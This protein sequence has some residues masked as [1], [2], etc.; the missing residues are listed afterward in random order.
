MN[1]KS[2]LNSEFLNTAYFYKAPETKASISYIEQIDLGETNGPNGFPMK[3]FGLKI[4]Q[5]DIYCD[6]IIFTKDE[7]NTFILINT[8]ISKL[9]N[10]YIQLATINDKSIRKTTLKPKSKLLLR[11]INSNSDILIGNNDIDAKRLITRIMHV[12]NSIAVNNR[13]GPATFMVISPKLVHLIQNIPG[14]IYDTNGKI[15]EYEVITQIGNVMGLSVFVNYDSHDDIILVGRY[16]S[17]NNLA[18]VALIENDIQIDT[19]HITWIGAIEEYSPTSQY[20]FELINVKLIDD[21]PWYKKLVY[22]F[23]KKRKIS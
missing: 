23:L 10:K 14:F 18:G 21:L 17:Q 2:Y 3:E 4:K 19:K 20:M 16:S 5:E 12:G 8:L 11:W 15:K 1:S 9:F 13:I 7:K 6:K 22:N